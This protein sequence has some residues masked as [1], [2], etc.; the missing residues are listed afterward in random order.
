MITHT[1]V[2]RSAKYSSATKTELLRVT[3]ALRFVVGLVG[4][5]RHF[6]LEHQELM[7]KLF[8]LQEE[9]EVDCGPILVF[10]A[11]RYRSILLGCVWQGQLEGALG[12][13]RKIL[14]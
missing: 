9:V 8:I 13:L 12:G 14:D 7:L 3:M 6:I 10:F 5:L 11:Y 1:I 2:R 4:T